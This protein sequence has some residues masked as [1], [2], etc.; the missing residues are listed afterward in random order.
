VTEVLTT[1][2]EPYITHVDKEDNFALDYWYRKTRMQQPCF[3]KWCAAT[4]ID[5]TLAWLYD[6]AGFRGNPATQA[7]RA[8]DMVDIYHLLLP[9]NKPS[10]GRGTRP[11]ANCP[12]Y[13]NILK[14]GLNYDTWVSCGNVINGPCIADNIHAAMRSGDYDIHA[15]TRKII[16]KFINKNAVKL[17]CRIF[18]DPQVA[19]D[20]S[21]RQIAQEE[22]NKE[23]LQEWWTTTAFSEIYRA[24]KIKNTLVL[25][26]S[27][28]EGYANH[29]V[30]AV[31]YGPNEIILYN[32][33]PTWYMQ[34]ATS[35]L[36]GTGN[37][38]PTK[39]L[40]VRWT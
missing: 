4:C 23:L 12:D 30:L 22:K 37:P 9:E 25:I 13:L 8:A 18:F 38:I 26:H 2:I 15:A 1:G 33:Q 16:F 21:G 34:T 11:E 31:G 24:L 14:Y 39:Y 35:S 32:P 28:F 10:T 27:I 20:P 7:N 5:I 36:F 40:I 6:K 17:T 29:V 19:R 3:S